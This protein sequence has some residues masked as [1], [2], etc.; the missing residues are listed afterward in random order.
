M[1]GPSREPPPEGA[2]RPWTLG[3]H[4]VALAVSAVHFAAGFTVLRRAQP[5]EGAYVVFRYANQ[6]AAGRGITYS[7]GG[8]RAE[9]A[10][11]FAWMV[12]LAVGRALG[13]DVALGA[14]VLNTAG[15]Y[16]AATIVASCLS[17]PGIRARWWAEA[18]PF[19][20]LVSCSAAAGYLGFSSMLYGALGLFAYWL[21]VAGGPARTLALP[22]AALLL[23]LF[24]PDGLI[25]GAGFAALGLWQ[26]R[27]LAVTARYLRL[28]G[29]SALVGGVYFVWR[30]RYFGHLLPLPLYARTEGV[31]PS[32]RESL[33]W[34]T[35]LAGPPLGV[36]VTAALLLPPARRARYAGPALGLLPFAVHVAAL[37][38]GLPAD[39]GVFRWQSP[40]LLPLS[41]LAAVVLA[42]EIAATGWRAR[43]GSAAI[44][45]WMAAPGFA[46]L[47][48]AVSDAAADTYVERFA[49]QLGRT[50]GRDD[51]LAVT[52]P[53]RIPYWSDARVVDLAGSNTWETAAEPP[54]VAY[55]EALAPDLVMLERSGATCTADVDTLAPEPPTPQGVASRVAADFLSH[56]RDDYQV[57]AVRAGEAQ[58]HVYGIRKAFVHAAAVEHLLAEAQTQAY[59]PYLSLP[60]P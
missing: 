42:T 44:L 13:L 15:A 29:A 19:L 20:L 49:V 27:R 48:L 59:Q 16:L 8:P 2:P 47:V 56:R 25:L 14:L 36:L 33:C 52:E 54:T 53:G 55:L 41:L 39:S 28:S 7:P 32:L 30:W 31:L 38:F 21:F 24:R 43:V 51:T 1:I 45:G 4:P 26:A 11:D 34:L 58:C 10:A 37:G 40:A 12:A 9:G 3:F 18:V 23:G 57:I 35:T 60:R 6:L 5:A 46:L 17:R 50:V 22:P